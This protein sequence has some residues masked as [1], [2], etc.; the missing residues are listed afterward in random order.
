MNAARTLSVD[1]NGPM[2]QGETLTEERNN[3]FRCYRYSPDYPAFRGRNLTPGDPI[4]LPGPVGTA[5]PPP[6][7]TRPGLVLAAGS[8]VQGRAAVALTLPVATNV[9]LAVYD[10]RGAQVALL[11]TG[12]L[13]S[14][15]HRLAWD[16]SA[17]AAGVY[18]CRLRAGDA[19]S[20]VKLV[21]PR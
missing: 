4:E 16:A 8:W 11:A 3:V 19:V 6:T 18:V 13:P 21:K 14:G 20:S 7:G 5:E 17:S 12:R 9:E 10:C 15:R 1:T 2:T